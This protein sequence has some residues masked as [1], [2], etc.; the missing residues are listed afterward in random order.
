MRHNANAFK[1]CLVLFFAFAFFKI[2]FYLLQSEYAFI[3]IGGSND[4]SYYDAIATGQLLDPNPWGVFLRF[5]NNHGLYSRWGISFANCLLNALVVPWLAWRL[6][7]SAKGSD[8]SLIGLL[9]FVFISVYPTVLYYT[10]DIHRDVLMV[11][12]FLI[13]ILLIKSLLMCGNLDP[14]A[15]KKNRIGYLLFLLVPLTILFML[16]F[17]LAAAMAVALVTCVF[18]DLS[19]K[20]LLPMLMY[21]S[22]LTAAN[23]LGYL[24]WMKIDYRLTYAAAGSVFGIDFSQGYFWVNFIQSAVMGLY[25]FYFKS[26]LSILIFVVE[27]IPV[28]LATVYLIWNRVYINRFASYLVIFFVCYASVWVIGVDSLGTA[29]RYRIFNYIALLI[30]VY[31]VSEQKKVGYE[32]RG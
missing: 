26:R 18:F 12:F 17:Y 32:A 22:A 3:A 2:I 14:A 30:A 31:E 13:S 5:L 21:V 27:S 19:K 28:I 15:V 25:G 4:A 6:L 29:V 8:L 11:V 7:K 9:I 24:D 1:G 20:I 10:T 23:L 16:R